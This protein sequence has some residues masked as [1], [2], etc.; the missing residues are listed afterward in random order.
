MTQI[1]KELLFEK[2]RDA[3]AKGDLRVASDATWGSLSL[4]SLTSKLSHITALFTYVRV[5][6][7]EEC[8]TAKIAFARGTVEI[9]AQ[10]FLDNL[11]L[12]EDLEFLIA[13]ERMHRVIH[14][15]G[16]PRS[17]DPEIENIR[18][19]IWINHAVAYA[20]PSHLPEHF[21][22][23][24]SSPQVLLTRNYPAIATALEARLKATATGRETPWHLAQ[25]I[26]NFL[27]YNYGTMRD[28]SQYNYSQWCEIMSETLVKRLFFDD[29][30]TVKTMSEGEDE[31]PQPAT[32]EGAPAQED[33]LD[34]ENNQDSAQISEDDD[35]TPS[36][37]SSKAQG[38]EDLKGPPQL[39]EPLGIDE[40]PINQALENVIRHPVTNG[41][42]QNL[43]PLFSPTSNPLSKMM[44]AISQE[45]SQI[46]QD[47][48]LPTVFDPED[49]VICGAG[50]TPVEWIH[51]AYQPSQ[52]LWHIY[53]DTSGSV[54]S[55]YPTIAAIARAMHGY[56]KDMWQ[57]ASRLAEVDLKSHQDRIL[58]GGGTNFN[59]V[60]TNILEKK[61]H[62]V[63]VVTDDE[64]SMDDN[65]KMEVKRTVKELILVEV[66]FL[67][68]YGPWQRLA[69]RRVPF[70]LITGGSTT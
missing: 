44:I 22:K 20:V 34:G 43:R 38:S 14:L 6:P 54:R 32:G 33:S 53:V 35:Q 16:H 37:G 27:R 48:D 51:K 5:V 39:V 65:L 57:F 42:P 21:Y 25:Q 59:A 55:F 63:V 50:H 60:A 69:N 23:D 52:P 56:C 1:T 40:D 67:A 10:F 11:Q 3:C 28:P 31:T 18:Q 64:G 24:T 7:Q 8:S 58:V 70:D 12:I 9:G 66:G 17:S 30:Q 26:V 45:G 49:L 13:H 4:L 46:Y 68:W 2:A 47:P 19:D 41:R 29:S 15:E 61:Q 62:Y 36:E